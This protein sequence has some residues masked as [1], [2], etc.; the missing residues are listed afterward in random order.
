M[1]VLTWESFIVECNQR[2]RNN[3]IMV[4]LKSVTQ[5]HASQRCNNI[6]LCALYFFI[7]LSN[8]RNGPKRAETEPANTER[9]VLN[10]ET[11]F[12]ITETEN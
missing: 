12:E 8:H 6:S 5:N 4:F 7:G 11:D 2:S 10:T 1:S 9:G 3:G